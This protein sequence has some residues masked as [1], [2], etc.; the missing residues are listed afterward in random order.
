MPTRTVGS[1]SKA[2]EIKRYYYFL[3]GKIGT[4]RGGSPRAA[5]MRILFFHMFDMGTGLGRRGL[6]AL[7]AARSSTELGHRVDVV[8]ARRPDPLGITTSE[9]LSIAHWHSGRKKRP[10]ELP[11]MKSGPRAEGDG[12]RRR[13]K[14]GTREIPPWFARFADSQ[15]HNLMALICWPSQ[16][17]IRIPLPHP[18]PRHG[19]QAS[20]EGWAVTVNC[21]AAVQ[22]RGARIRHQF[23]RCQG[24]VE[25][26]RGQI[27]VMGGRREPPFVLSSPSSRLSGD[28]LI[29]FGR[30]V[31]EKGLW[32]LLEAMGRQK[33]ATK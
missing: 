5:D 9:L 2:V 16:Q 13:G 24:S 7:R 26:C 3:A 23:F 10:G 14:V 20:L 18:R 6:D 22:G 30:L 19:H 4:E 17:E 21:S 32:I 28:T 8:S 33:A 12:D 29:Y 27:E 1:S 25:H 11:W 31:T 15:S